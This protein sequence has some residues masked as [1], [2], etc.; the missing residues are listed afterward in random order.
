[1][2]ESKYL[3]EIFIDQAVISDRVH[4]GKLS[5]I[6]NMF[7]HVGIVSNLYRVVSNDPEGIHQTGA[8]ISYPRW[9]WSIRALQRAQASY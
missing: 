1:M 5:W 3:L 7:Q 2:L 6:K 4:M 9:P 8:I